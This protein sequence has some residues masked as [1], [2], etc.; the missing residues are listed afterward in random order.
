MTLYFIFFSWDNFH[1]Q[2]WSAQVCPQI[3]I[4]ISKAKPRIDVEWYAPS[5]NRRR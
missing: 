2:M 3:V 5:V 4:V 1:P